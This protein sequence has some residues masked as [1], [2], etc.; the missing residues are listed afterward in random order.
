MRL[1]ASVRSSLNE[2]D[3]VT[4]V[5]QNGEREWGRTTS[6]GASLN[7]RIG[8]FLSVVSKCETELHNEYE[9]RR[10]KLEA[11]KRRTAVGGDST[12]F[13]ARSTSVSSRRTWNTQQN[14]IT[15]RSGRT[16]RTASSIYSDINTRRQNQRP[17]PMKA[18][19][20]EEQ[21]R[22][23]GRSRSSTPLARTKSKVPATTVTSASTVSKGQRIGRNRPGSAAVSNNVRPESGGTNNSRSRS[24]NS[25]L[26]NGGGVRP[27]SAVVKRPD[28]K[29][30]SAKR[31]VVSSN[32]TM[33][34]RFSRSSP[35]VK[36]YPIPDTSKVRSRLKQDRNYQPPR[37]TR[38][39]NSSSVPRTKSNKLKANHNRRNGGYHYED[40]FEKEDNETDLEEEEGYGDDDEDD[41]RPDMSFTRRWLNE[42]AERGAARQRAIHMNSS[43]TAA[44]KSRYG[45]GNNKASSYDKESSQ[46][47]AYGFSGGEQSKLHT[48]EP[49][50]DTYH[51]Q[52]WQL[53]HFQQQQQRHHHRPVIGRQTSSSRKTSRSPEVRQRRSFSNDTS[54][55]TPE[56]RGRNTPVVVVKEDTNK[57][58]TV[59]PDKNMKYVNFLNKVTSDILARG[60]F[61][62]K[63]IKEI[64]QCNVSK[65]NCNGDQSSQVTPA[66]AEVLLMKLR[67]EFGLQQHPSNNNSELLKSPQVSLNNSLNDVSLTDWLQRQQKEQHRQ[68]EAKR[69]QQQ[70]RNNN[71]HRRNHQRQSRDNSGG[72]GGGILS[73]SYDLDDEEL[74]GLIKDL[75][76]DDSTAEVV[77]K[78]LKDA[79]DEIAARRQNRGRSS[80]T[81]QAAAVSATGE[82]LLPNK[83]E[84]FNSMNIADLNIS[85]NASSVQAAKERRN[86]EKALLI[87]S[88]A[89]KHSEQQEHGNRKAGDKK[90]KA[91]SPKTKNVRQDSGSSTDRRKRSSETPLS[92]SSPLYQ[93]EEEEESEEEEINKEEDEA[94][95]EMSVQEETERN[96]EISD[97]DNKDGEIGEEIDYEDDFSSVDS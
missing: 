97:N 89:R 92:S 67:Q 29:M 2:L 62:D 15:P 72:Q 20:V 1:P 87:K 50:P 88:F 95:E 54:V 64:L 12:T 55:V 58:K 94:P 66:E 18:F 65:A 13:T 38:R 60:I 74:S 69:V 76:L 47:S 11:R 25:R 23:I 49:T 84:F 7:D 46:D 68:Q 83:S 28:S 78:A 51:L 3:R 27:G 75:D 37:N 9:D 32:N 24:N 45:S 6:A 85:F 16:G 48:R 35:N 31:S 30:S 4:S 90:V 10:R 40:D 39:P 44:G 56:G 86:K 22:R 43:N 14:T 26:S 34:S 82:V 79:D 53:Q 63:A 71:E 70:R 52:A 59:Y 93:P 5:S 77:A 57:K 96:D 42:Q 61:T 41:G 73:S 17:P 33:N 91:N 36:E 8:H 80:E 81:P 21:Q 19:A